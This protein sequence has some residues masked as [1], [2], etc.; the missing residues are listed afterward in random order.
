VGSDFCPDLSD[1]F[2][3]RNNSGVEVLRE[4]LEPSHT[5]DEKYLNYLLRL[6]DGTIATGIITEEEATYLTV[7]SGADIGFARTIDKRD[8]FQRE[9]RA[10]SIMPVG[11]LDTL[12]REQIVDLIAFLKYGTSF[13]SP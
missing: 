1:I 11:L 12:K 2:E 3:R 13:Q 4:I 6:N 8:I 7:Q 9:K 10:V 5:I